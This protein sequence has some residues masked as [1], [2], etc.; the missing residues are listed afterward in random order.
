MEDEDG[1]PLEG[2]VV[3]LKD[4]GSG[5][6]VD[7]EITDQ[8]G[9]FGFFDVTFGE[10]KVLV[11]REGY[12]GYETVTLSISEGAP[13]LDVGDIE[14]ERN[15]EVEIGG[16]QDWTWIGVCLSFGIAGLVIVLLV[17]WRRGRKR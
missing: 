9:G 16:S 8:D 13:T 15:P 7:T 6:V 4:A 3:R 12:I 11:M 5:D 2:A 1:N 10:Y 17:V 14:L